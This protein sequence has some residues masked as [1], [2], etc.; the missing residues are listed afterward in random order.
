MILR[1][2]FFLGL[3]ERISA[4]GKTILKN[5][6]LH[7]HFFTVFPS[8]DTCT[9][10]YICIYTLFFERRTVCLYFNVFICIH[11]DKTVYGFG[12]SLFVPSYFLY[13]SY[14]RITFFRRSCS[15]LERG[16]VNFRERDDIEISM[17]PTGVIQCANETLNARNNYSYS[18]FVTFSYRILIAVQVIYSFFYLKQSAARM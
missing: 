9:N 11:V 16:N 7:L 15:T 1:H 4:I 14:A 13:S 17:D 12:S 2:S 6:V 18:K 10:K 3:A 5:L 8:P